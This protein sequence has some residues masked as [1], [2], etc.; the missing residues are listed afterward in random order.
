M[1]IDADKAT[2]QERL[3]QIDNT[4]EKAGQAKRQDGERVAIFVPKRNIET[5]LAYLQGQT[6]DEN[7]IYPRLRQERDCQPLVEKLYQMCQSGVLPAPAPPSL[8]AAC[9]EYNARLRQ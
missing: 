8:L 2:V 4:T 3:T 6:V 9:L 5:W 7:D 1:L